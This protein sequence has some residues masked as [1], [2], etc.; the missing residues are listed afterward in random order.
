MSLDQLSEEQYCAISHGVCPR[1]RQRAIVVLASGFGSSHPIDIACQACRWSLVDQHTHQLHVARN[2]IVP[3]LL[4]V[5]LYHLKQLQRE[6]E[7]LRSVIIGML[8]N[9]AAIEPGPLD[10]FLRETHSTRISWKVLEQL[11]GRGQTQSLKTQVQPT[12]SSQLMIV[13]YAGSPH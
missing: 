7:K 4:L 1:C 2:G 11:V 6:Y 12:A 10:V 9:R 13:R 3:Q 8:E 5:R